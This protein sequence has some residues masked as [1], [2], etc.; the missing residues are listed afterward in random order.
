MNLADS[1]KLV[2]KNKSQA[3]F[4]GFWR[5]D[6]ANLLHETRSDLSHVFKNGYHQYQAIRKNGLKSSAHE[7]IDSARDVFIIFRI[8][9]RRVKR[10][11]IQFRDDFIVELDKLP[12]QKQK[13]IFCIKVLGA[14]S[15]FAVGAVYNMKLGKLDYSFTGIKRRNAF[16]QFLIAELIFK[17]SQVFI[18]RFLNEV[19]KHLT[20][21]DEL[22][23]LRYFK[24]LFS[25]RNK[26]EE[27]VEHLEEQEFEQDRSITIVDD[28]KHYILTGKKTN[29]N[30]A[31]TEI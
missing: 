7:L 29:H 14:L 13:T 10:G 27:E 18:M 30:K 22:N 15:S 20:D 6:L 17:I 31:M 3:I 8:I 11:F 24:A 2:L 25:D 5:D 28:L 16:T 9:P 19:E 4:S 23:N 26:L 21:P 1:V 12:E